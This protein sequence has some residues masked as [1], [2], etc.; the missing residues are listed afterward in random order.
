MNWN[1]INEPSRLKV[2]SLMK[3]FDA[4]ILENHRGL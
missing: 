3:A 1:G 4:F 2:D